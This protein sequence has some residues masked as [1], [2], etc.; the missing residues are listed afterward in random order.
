MTSSRPRNLRTEP[1]VPR[2]VVEGIPNMMVGIQS[3]SSSL[4]KNE[5]SPL[6]ET[7]LRIIL[8]RGCRR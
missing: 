7:F 2:T 3:N 6:P 1:A 5:M 4:S 8:G